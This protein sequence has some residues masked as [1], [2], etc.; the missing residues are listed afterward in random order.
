MLIIMLILFTLPFTVRTKADLNL[1]LQVHSALNNLAL[2]RIANFLLII[3]HLHF[4]PSDDEDS[5]HKLR[6]YFLLK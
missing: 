6:L 3:F 5:N 1:K 4:S 2:L